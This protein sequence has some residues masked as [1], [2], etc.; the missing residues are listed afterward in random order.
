MLCRTVGLFACLLIGALA[1]AS[2]AGFVDEDAANAVVVESLL[3]RYT[4]QRDD[5][6]AWS[7]AKT[8]EGQGVKGYVLD[9]TSQTWRDEDEVSHP[10]WTHMVQIF[11]PDPVVLSPAATSRTPAGDAAESGSASI[12]LSSSSGE[13]RA[14]GVIL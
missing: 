4:A 9:L 2:W 14:V 12:V 11:V 7:L 5:S 10:A 8:Y 13:D 6:F 3:D 1:R